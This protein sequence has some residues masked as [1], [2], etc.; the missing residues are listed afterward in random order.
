MKKPAMN[1]LR[2]IRSG[3]CRGLIGPPPDASCDLLLEANDLTRARPA[4]IRRAG[5]RR[6]GVETG[7]QGLRRDAREPSVYRVR[8][9]PAHGP[10]LSSLALARDDARP[11]ADHARR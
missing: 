3:P 5:P 7:S 10:F 2:T 11:R 4:K 1:L 8:R 6:S 9:G